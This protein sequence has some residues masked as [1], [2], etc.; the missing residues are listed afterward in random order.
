M[1][2]EEPVHGNTSVVTSMLYKNCNHFKNLKFVDNIPCI[3]TL[4]DDLLA[5]WAISDMK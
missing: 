5:F 4:D 3:A 2:T 1:G